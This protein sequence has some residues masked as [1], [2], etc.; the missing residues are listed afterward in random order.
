[1]RKSEWNEVSLE[2]FF[3]ILEMYR[4]HMFPEKILEVAGLCEYKI[5]GKPGSIFFGQSIDFFND[6]KKYSSDKMTESL[7]RLPK[8]E[9]EKLTQVSFCAVSGSIV[10]E[11]GPLIAPILGKDHL[12]LVYWSWFGGKMTDDVKGQIVDVRPAGYE[13][14]PPY[15]FW[16]YKKEVD[17][18]KYVFPPDM[19]HK[20]IE[21]EEKGLRKYVLV[22]VVDHDFFIN[23]VEEYIG[24]NGKPSSDMLG[25]GYPTKRS[26]YLLD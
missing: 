19:D 1:M 7:E 26:L 5:E 3:E 16:Y 13:F 8:E 11:E 21:Q 15:Q 20:K 25:P 2:A 23:S 17:K 24:T 22:R 14:R 10:K 12:D 18:K 4:N 6:F 9:L